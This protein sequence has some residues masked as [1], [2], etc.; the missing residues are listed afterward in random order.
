MTES[1]TITERPGAVRFSVRVVPR[2]SRSGIEGL[3]GGGLKVRLNAPP[4]E[5]AANE[6][7]VEVIAGAL[8][9]PRS[10]VRIAGGG[11]SRTKLVEVQG[12]SADTV[13]QKIG[14]EPQSAN[15]RRSGKS[16]RG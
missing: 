15:D 16:P 7:L 6:E 2:A 1:L 13:R 3:H 4:V 14:M 11:H 10:W 8:G 9:V 5:G 12:V